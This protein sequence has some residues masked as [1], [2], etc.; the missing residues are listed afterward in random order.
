MAKIK[1]MGTSD[2]RVFDKGE[3][4]GG[5]LAEPLTKQVVWSP[6]NNHLVDSEEVGLSD[7]AVTLILDMEG[8]VFGEGALLQPGEQSTARTISEFKDVSDMKMIPSSLNQQI[9]RG[10]KTRVARDEVIDD[11]DNVVE[12][13]DAP[14]KGEKVTASRAASRSSGGGT[15]GGGGTAAVGGSTDGAGGD[16]GGVATT[17]TAGPGT[18]TR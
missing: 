2:Y 6:E 12:T 4:F 3:N 16:T 14:T 11:E 9:Y 18:G 8:T 10:H 13:D 7:E 17:G 1:Y 15:T 5:Q